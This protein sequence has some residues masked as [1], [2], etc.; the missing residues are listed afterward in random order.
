MITI[1]KCP[2][3]GDVRWDSYEDERFPGVVYHFLICTRQT[4]KN[5]D[6]NCASDSFLDRDAAALD[7]NRKVEKKSKQGGND[8]GVS[9]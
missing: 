4:C 6:W 2:H 1:K 7:W 9:S 5:V 8:Y 3:G